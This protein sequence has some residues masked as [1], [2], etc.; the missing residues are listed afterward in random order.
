MPKYVLE[1]VDAGPILSP[2][3]YIVDGELI[4]DLVDSNG[5]SNNI[6]TFKSDGTLKLHVLVDQWAQAA[7]IQRGVGGRM[8]LC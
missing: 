3:F 4:F 8:L 6:L 2:R 7:G 1:R 5:D